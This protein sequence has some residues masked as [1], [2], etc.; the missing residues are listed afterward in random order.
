MNKSCPEQS[1]PPSEVHESLDIQ[2]ET[3]SSDQEL[4][5][6]ISFHSAFPSHSAFHHKV[7][8]MLMPYIE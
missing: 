1:P 8:T 2:A 5:S 4:D 3:S 7:P 6:E